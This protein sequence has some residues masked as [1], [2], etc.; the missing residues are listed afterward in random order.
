MAIDLINPISTIDASEEINAQGHAVTLG[1][2]DSHTHLNAQID[3]DAVMTTLSWRGMPRTPREN[4]G[5]IFAR[6]KR[7]T[8]ESF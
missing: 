2:V 1:A 5:V 7:Q 8:T 3:G 6:G 4:C